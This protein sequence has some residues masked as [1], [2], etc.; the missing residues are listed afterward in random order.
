MFIT[1]EDFK[2]NAF[3]PNAGASGPLSDVTGNETELTEFIEEYEF[4][5]IVLIM[6]Y[7]LAKEF[8]SKFDENGELISGEDEMWLKLLEGEGRYRGI[9]KALVNYV[10]FKFISND[11][12]EY[13]GTGTA[14]NNPK[15]MEQMSITRKAVVAWNKFHEYAV[16]KESRIV[17]VHNN[18]GTGVIWDSS[19][20]SFMST[21]EFIKTESV[22]FEPFNLATYAVIENINQYGL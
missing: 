14:Q 12:I 6:G 13:A 5:V 10:F 22:N 15:G 7:E 11:E 21:R 17:V 8:V 1:T 18:M 3:V 2:G 19:G 20:N 4:S 9:K 16:G